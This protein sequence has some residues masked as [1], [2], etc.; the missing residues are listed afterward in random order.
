MSTELERVSPERLDIQYPIENLYENLDSEFLNVYKNIPLEKDYEKPPVIL[1]SG[2]SGSGKDTVLKPLVQE[3]LLSHV[4]TAT[5]RAR[6]VENGEPESAYVWMREQREDEDE[7]IYHK[8]LIKEYE[9][10]EHSFHY[11]N[12]YGLPLFS[13]KRDMSSIPVVRTDI[14]GVNSLRKI[15][16][17]YGFRTISV[18]VLATSWQ[19]CY[20]SILNRDCEKEHQ[21][22]ERIIEDFYNTE[23]YLNNINYFIVNSREPLGSGITGLD[24]S[25]SGLRNIVRRYGTLEGAH[26][27]DL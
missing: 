16:P 23:K 15:L 7:N 5:T 4:V 11:G 26:E 1:L 27:I 2:L 24:I 18:G 3:G 12:F 10:I 19:E 20:E 8:A 6:R 21:A 13:I 22:R 14:N 9:L 25:I 17:E